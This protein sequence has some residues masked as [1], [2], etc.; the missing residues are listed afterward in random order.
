MKTRAMTVGAMLLGVSVSAAAA[1]GAITSAEVPPVPPVLEVPSGHELYLAGYAEG[2]QNYVCLPAK[3]SVRWQ[4][5]G[6]QATLFSTRRGGVW[7]QITTHFLSGNPAEAA[8]AR[9]TWQHSLDSSRVWGRALAASSDANYVEAGAIPW[10][11]VEAVGTAD[12]PAG[13]G[14]LAQTTFIQRLNTSGGIAPAT[15]CSDASHI[16]TFALV[17]Y[18]TDYFFYRGVH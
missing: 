7:Q 11:L 1:Q 12:G 6:P 5:L 15:G 14:A 17:P 18:T 16:G 10:L 13:G 3:K 2:T 9:P 4:F 8:T